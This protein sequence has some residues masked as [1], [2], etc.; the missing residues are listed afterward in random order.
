MRRRVLG[1]LVIAVAGVVS[2]AVAK[3]ARRGKVVRVERPRVTS[4]ESLRACLFSNANED[5]FTCFGVVPPD[6]GDLFI[7]VDD[8]GYRGRARVTKVDI[9]EYDN[10]KLGV[11][12]DVR[13]EYDDRSTAPATGA[14]YWGSGLALRGVDVDTATAKVITDHSRLRSPSGKDQQVWM[15]IDLTGDGFPDML[16][17]WYDGCDNPTIRPTAPPN[18]TLKPLC[19]DY[20]L[21]EDGQWQLKTTDPYYLC[22]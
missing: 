15:A 21:K 5:K 17:T 13:F 18:R 6:I 9:G 19:L 12:H 3:P 4:R 10:C 14:R 16:S 11:S 8:N 2:V 20:W 1:L 22:M 7:V